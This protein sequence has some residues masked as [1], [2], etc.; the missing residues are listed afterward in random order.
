[1]VQELWVKNTSEYDSVVVVAQKRIKR[2][3]IFGI[4]DALKEG[5][6]NVQL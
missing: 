2:L 1:M 5:C 4:R 6:Y 3:L